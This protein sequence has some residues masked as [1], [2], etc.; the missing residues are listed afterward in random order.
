MDL[1]QLADAQ[2]RMQPVRT[3]RSEENPAFHRQ[4]NALNAK[5]DCNDRPGTAIKCWKHSRHNV[6]LARHPTMCPALDR[7]NSKGGALLFDRR[8]NGDRLWPAAPRMSEGEGEAG[9]LGEEGAAF[10]LLTAVMVYRAFSEI[11][12][13]G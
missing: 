3:F 1:F 2:A 8:P 5:G 12:A 9:R 6:Q 4:I 7:L 11:D 13:N 10:I